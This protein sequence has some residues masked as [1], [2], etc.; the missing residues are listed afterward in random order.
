MPTANRGW[1]VSMIFASASAI[2][3]NCNPG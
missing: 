2:G 1:L 3:S